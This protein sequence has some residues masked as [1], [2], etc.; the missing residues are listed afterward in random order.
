MNAWI[1]ASITLVCTFGSAL[2]GTFIRKSVPD[3]HMGKESQDVV[4]LGMGLVATMTA[5]LLGLVTASAKGSF[6]AQDAAVNAIAV[7]ILTMDRNLAQYGPETTPVRDQLR[8]AVEYRLESTWPEGGVAR[9]MTPT[10]T[11]ETVEEIETQI[12]ALNPATESQRWFRSQALSLYQEV[13]KTRWRVLQAGSGS[14]PSAFLVVV[15]LW[16]MMTFASFGLYAPRNTTVVAA[17][18]VAA[19]SVSA[20][21][22]LILE[23]GTPYDGVIKVSG[24]PFRFLVSQLGK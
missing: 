6:D 15:I 14:V 13:K 24:N 5:L 16:L 19:L 11:S 1:I 21:V 9:P 7:N 8:R 18:F 10:Q 3:S 23:L 20:A 12:L 2:L 4:R 17:L 22:F